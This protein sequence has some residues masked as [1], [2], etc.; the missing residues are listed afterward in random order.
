MIVGGAGS[1]A[2]QRLATGEAVNVAARLEQAAAPGEVLIGSQTYGLVR[3]AVVAEAVEPIEAKGLSEP[4]AAW[5]LVAVRPEVPAFAQQ[6][7]TPFVGGRTS[8]AG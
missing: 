8:S 3:D 4:V 5:R 1:A 2:D 6:I 7:R